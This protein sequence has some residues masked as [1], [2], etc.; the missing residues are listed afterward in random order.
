MKKVYKMITADD[1]KITIDGNFGTFP[2]AYCL[3]SVT[4]TVSKLGR[5]N[6]TQPNKVVGY[7]IFFYQIAV[8]K[9]HAVVSRLQ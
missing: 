1:Y 6:E 4:Y 9:K 5:P 8:V 7:R 3:V 2:F